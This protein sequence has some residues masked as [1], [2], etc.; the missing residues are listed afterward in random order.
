MVV[1]FLMEKKCDNCAEMSNMCV[2]FYR[3]SNRLG[4]QS[5]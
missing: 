1:F 2:G 4:V 3:Q 5:S